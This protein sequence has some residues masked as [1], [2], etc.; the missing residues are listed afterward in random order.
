MGED[1]LSKICLAT[2]CSRWKIRDRQEVSNTLKQTL[3]D[4]AFAKNW[5]T[6]KW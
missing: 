1:S 5:M 2:K 3:P 6:N 4:T